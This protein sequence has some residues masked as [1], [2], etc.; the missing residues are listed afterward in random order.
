MLVSF[1]YYFLLVW[2][3]IYYH[4]IFIVFTNLILFFCYLIF[5]FIGTSIKTIHFFL[6]LYPQEVVFAINYLQFTLFILYLIFAIFPAKKIECR[7]SRYVFSL[8]NTLYFQPN[9]CIRFTC[10]VPK[11]P[12]YKYIY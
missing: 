8:A 4:N 7:F 11:T 6:L 1:F 12:K 10:I 3:I 5:I 9:V 2:L